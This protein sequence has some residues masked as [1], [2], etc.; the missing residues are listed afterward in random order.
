MGKTRNHTF[1]HFGHWKLPQHGRLSL[2][3]LFFLALHGVALLQLKVQLPTLQLT[4]SN[5]IS[6]VRAF[7]KGSDLFLG[8]D[9]AFQL[10]FQD[11]SIVAKPTLSHLPSE[12]KMNFVFE[13]VENEL[14]TLSPRELMELEGGADL[15]EQAKTV[16]QNSVPYFSVETSKKGEAVNV[17][18]LGSI[19][20]GN[21]LQSRFSGLMP[22]LSSQSTDRPLFPTVIR[23][24]VSPQGV[25]E[26]ALI[27]SSSGNIEVD[28]E[29]ITIA[30]Q[31][32]FVASPDEKMVWSTLTFYW[33]QIALEDSP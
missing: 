31:L 15:A 6:P 11:P 13:Q 2:L 10:R 18:E 19:V 3:F 33:P 1:F 7:F 30:N 20:V 29:A 23:V 26:T 22:A 14:K 25:V 9:I 12:A 16:S 17:V 32:R 21:E 24:S 27:E 4:T 8:E 5:K 28:E